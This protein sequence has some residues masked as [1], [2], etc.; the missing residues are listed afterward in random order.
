MCQFVVGKCNGV[1]AILGEGVEAIARTWLDLVPLDARSQRQERD[2]SSYHH[3][4]IINPRERGEVPAIDQFDGIDLSPVGL[5]HKR[6]NLSEIWYVVI[7][8]NWVNKL[9]RDAGLVQKDLHV[10]I[11]I[12]GVDM[13]D[14]AKGPRTIQSY[15]DIETLNKLVQNLNSSCSCENTAELISNLA[16]HFM[17][18]ASP[19]SIRFLPSAGETVFFEYLIN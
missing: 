17:K 8:S 4:T 13:H 2:S 18:E 6:T 12:R 11:G 14:V 3:I 15:A 9:R 1:Y 16:S 10:T 5:G 7:Y 19:K